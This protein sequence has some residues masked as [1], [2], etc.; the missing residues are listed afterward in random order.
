MP[1][2]SFPEEPDTEI[3]HFYWE[4]RAFQFR[5]DIHYF[6]LIF[7]TPSFYHTQFLKPDLY[8]VLKAFELI[9]K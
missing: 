9:W 1:Q 3:R 7:S 4:E 2:K 5:T 6:P 8:N